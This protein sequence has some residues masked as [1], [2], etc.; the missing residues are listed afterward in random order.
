[1]GQTKAKNLLAHF[2]TIKAIRTAEPEEI[3]K[4]RGVSQKNAEDIYK[5][6]HPE[7]K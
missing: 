2:R 3:A 5:Y 1:I 6:Y 7:D 4:V